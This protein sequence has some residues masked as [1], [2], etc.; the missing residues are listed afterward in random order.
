MYTAQ[1]GERGQQRRSQAC[2]PDLRLDNLVS[3]LEAPGSEGNFGSPTPSRA[4]EAGGPTAES[5]E[6]AG[7]SSTAPSATPGTDHDRDAAR[8][9]IVIDVRH[10]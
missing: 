5:R 3:L 7:R 4:P 2:A 9:G 10:Q 8:L 6:N 1:P